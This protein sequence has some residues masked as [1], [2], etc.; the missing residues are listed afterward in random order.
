[1]FGTQSAR[2]LAGAIGAASPRRYI[3]IGSGFSSAVLLDIND[4]W[5]RDDPIELTFIDP[6]P[7]RL[8]S[9]LREGDRASC[10]IIPTQVQ[11]VDLRVFDQLQPGDVLFIDS[12]HLAK[13]GS[14]V[15]TEIFEILPRL[16]VGVRIHLHDISYPFDYP[17]SWLV[18]QNRSWN[19]AYFL[20]AFLMYNTHFAVH[21]WTDFLARFA[22]ELEGVESIDLIGPGTSS[23]WLT[24]VAD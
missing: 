15:L 16:A 18:E 6:H 23:I 8:E 17:T 3:E 5:R 2:L 19:E 1:M 14:D 13:A 7:E 9:I 22:A 11:A 24:R 10:T 4:E 20:R 21:L 12:T